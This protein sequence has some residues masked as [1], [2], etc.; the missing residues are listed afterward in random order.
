ML[1]CLDP[2]PT[3]AGTPISNQLKPSASADTRKPQARR[4]MLVQQTMWASAT[5]KVLRGHRTGRQ[6]SQ[7]GKQPTWD[8]HALPKAQK[9]ARQPPGAEAGRGGTVGLSRGPSGRPPRRL[10][11]QAPAGSPP[12]WHRTPAPRASSNS[13]PPP[14]HTL[15]QPPRVLLVQRQQ[16]PR[17]L[18][19]LGQRELDPPDLALVAQPILACVGGGNGE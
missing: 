19:D 17:S 15:K 18:A 5:L 14:A 13:R 3:D 11:A 1:E 2:S 8:T 9:G 10:P 16:L 7:A 4:I 6:L 12:C